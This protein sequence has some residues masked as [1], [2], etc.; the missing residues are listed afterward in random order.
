MALFF[1]FCVVLN[2]NIPAST[3]QNSLSIPPKKHSRIKISIP[4][5]PTCIWVKHIFF[6]RKG[7]GFQTTLCVPGTIHPVIDVLSSINLAD[8][9]GH[10]QMHDYSHCC[11]QQHPI[12]IHWLPSIVAYTY[13]MW[14]CFWTCFV[15]PQYLY[16]ISAFI[17]STCFFSVYSKMRVGKAS[18]P[19]YL[20][21]GLL[22]GS[23]RAFSITL[24]I[25][26]WVVDL[27]D[28]PA[29]DQKFGV[30]LSYLSHQHRK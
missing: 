3:N 13:R 9:L 5:L 1:C 23:S 16:V 27:W 4:W 18:H 26:S 2:G 20:A 25:A 29:V 24:V 7:P 15:S 14:L 10:H 19:M 30:D 12:M 21:S 6:L 11:W 22:G 8:K 28:D 17:I